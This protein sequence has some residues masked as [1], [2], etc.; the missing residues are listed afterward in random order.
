MTINLHNLES[1]DREERIEVINAIREQK[2]FY[3]L[4]LLIDHL[5]REAEQVIREKIILVIEELFPEAGADCIGRMVRSEDAFTRNSAV[6]IMKK[7]DDAIVPVL[8]DLATDSNNDVRKF[9]IDALTTRDTPEVRKILKERL[10]DPDPNVVYTAV[11]YLGSLKDV[12]AAGAIELLATNLDDNPMLFCSCLEALAKI[13][14]K[15]C[16]LDLI[17]YCQQKGREPL[18]RYSILKYM[19]SCASYEAVEALILELA[20]Q[21]G[22]LFAKEI[23]DTMEAICRRE[24]LTVISPQLKEILK[25]LL[26]SVETGESRYELAKL[27]AD[28]VDVEESRAAARLDLASDRPM[29]VMAAIEIL[30]KYGQENDIA[31]LEKLADKTDSDEILELIGDAVAQISTSEDK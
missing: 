29:V 5:E 3:A 13:G 23:I 28:N 30:S 24:P 25:R 9:A 21:S 12:D 27:L 16:S 1:S 11:E 22:E 14:V 10:S 20:S 19:G 6:E 26:I 8:A 2:S 7:A 17:A 31:L 15:A 4:E 18:F